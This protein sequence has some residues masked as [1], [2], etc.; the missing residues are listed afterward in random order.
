VR[1]SWSFLEGST[2]F[3]L[4]NRGLGR[5]WRNRKGRS[6]IL[7]RPQRFRRVARSLRGSCV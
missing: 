6:T 3:H 4:Q 5:P 2:I 1:G 7:N